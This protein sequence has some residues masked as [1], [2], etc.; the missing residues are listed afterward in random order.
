MV[1]V[2][3]AVAPSHEQLHGNVIDRESMESKGTALPC[4]CAY[5]D[6][7]QIHALENGETVKEREFCLTRH[8]RN[9]NLLR[10][11]PDYRDSTASMIQHMLF[12][13]SRSL[14][15]RRV[16][17]VSSLLLVISTVI[18]HQCLRK[19]YPDL[20]PFL[21]SLLTTHLKSNIDIK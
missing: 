7:R 8:S 1:Q 21:S 10:H 17:I 16:I 11:H 12:D 15:C 14:T 19:L 13:R 6:V 4:D 20:T 9:H 3:T 18:N 2:E 5:I